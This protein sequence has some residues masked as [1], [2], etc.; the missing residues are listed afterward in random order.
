MMSKKIPTK[1]D[2]IPKWAAFLL[3]AIPLA[4]CAALLTGC[5]DKN[6]DG[7]TKG[8]AV[9]IYTDNGTGCQYVKSRNDL[10]MA[11]RMGRDSKQVCAALMVGA[12]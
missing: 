5:Y 12:K 4:F 10:Q 11:P 3:V 6:P 1:R 2:V 7:T 9:M 8:D